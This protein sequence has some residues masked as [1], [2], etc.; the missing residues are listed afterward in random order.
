MA[1]TGRD[2]GGVHDKLI[3]VMTAVVIV[4]VLTMVV[5]SGDGRKYDTVG[6]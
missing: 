4:L 1:E 5:A 2:D 6:V 3:V